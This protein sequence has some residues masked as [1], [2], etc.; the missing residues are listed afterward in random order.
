MLYSMSFLFSL[1]G[2]GIKG[3][4]RL[5]L[6]S[7]FSLCLVSLKGAGAGGIFFYDQYYPLFLDRVSFY[8][9]I[10]SF[11]ITYLSVFSRFYHV[12]KRELVK[13]GFLLMFIFFL[14]V[15][16]FS[17]RG[18]L[19]FFVVFEFVIIPMVFVIR[20]WGSQKE[21]LTANYYFFFYT[22]LRGV[23]LIVVILYLLKEGESCFLLIKIDRSMNLVSIG[24]ILA[25]F[26][27]FLCKLPIYRFH[28]WLP[29]AHVEAPVRGSMVLA[30]LLLKIGGYGIIRA[31]MVLSVSLSLR[32]YVFISFLAVRILYP[33]FICLRQV[34]LKSFIAYSSVRHISIAL[35]GLMVYNLYR[36]LRGFVVF[37]R[38]RLISPLMFYSVNLIYERVGTRIVVRMRRFDSNLKF[39]FYYFLLVFVANIRYP[40]FVSF[41]REVSLYLR[42]TNFSFSFLYFLFIFLFFS[43]VVMVYFLV[44]I[45][46]GRGVRSKYEHLRYREIIIYWL[47]LYLLCIMTLLIFVF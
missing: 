13:Y 3:R 5:L 34:D 10:L 22:L 33:I 37:L 39:F 20:I 1:R 40:P 27:A 7:F 21:R 24:S 28:I 18:Y 42:L 32:K 15:V 2:K 12:K 43:R 9:V 47:G 25:I 14:L 4:V 6:L 11:L 36:Y 41:F 30:R 45:F 19:R 46:K 8:L 31:F 26:L 29:K 23:P 35:A 44:K 38:H 17:I 16:L